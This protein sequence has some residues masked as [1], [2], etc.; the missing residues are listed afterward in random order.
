MMFL[1]VVL[2]VITIVL[3]IETSFQEPFVNNRRR[4]A[5]AQR[6]PQTMAPAAAA[7]AV[8]AAPAAARLGTGE[9]VPV[10]FPGTGQINMPSIIQPQ[11]G[12]LQ[13]QGAVQLG[14]QGNQFMDFSTGGGTS[15]IKFMN[16][17]QQGLI[18][19]S[20]GSGGNNGDMVIQSRSVAFE[21]PVSVTGKLTASRGT[22]GSL[23]VNRS[24]GDRYPN[25]GAGIH[26]WDLYA[27][28]SVGAGQDGNVVAYLNSNGDMGCTRNAN[29]TNIYSQ[30]VNIR[31][32]D[33]LA[34]LNNL[35]NELQ[36]AKRRI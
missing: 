23:K 12:P 1:L 3:G 34:E 8:V 31:G 21:A 32:R 36:N 24:D 29:L 20:G 15:T 14:V 19:S 25:W 9:I 17:G 2:V 16:N 11:N 4:Q 13:V 10:A 28:G 30:Y 27:N 26:T 6:R 18:Q 33:I 7:M 22:F 5:Y 35:H